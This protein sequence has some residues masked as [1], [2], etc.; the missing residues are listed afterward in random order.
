MTTPDARDSTV[1]APDP[2]LAKGQVASRTLQFVIFV[3][4]LSAVAVG[5][6]ADTGTVWWPKVVTAAGGAL[7]GTSLS[8][9]LASFQSE[10]VAARIAR[11]LDDVKADVGASRREVKS[12]LD[13]S[14]NAAFRSEGDLAPLKRRWHIYHLARTRGQWGWQAHVLDFQRCEEP[15]VLR[16][17]MES[18]S[19][20]GEPIHYHVDAGIRHGRLVIFLNDPHSAQGAHA[21]LVF[22]QAG[23]L[24][25]PHFGLGLVNAADGTS[26]V[27]PVAAYLDAPEGVIASAGNVT[28]GAGDLSRQ[29]KER[30]LESVNDLKLPDEV[31]TDLFEAK[32]R[33][34]QSEEDRDAALRR[35]ETAEDR[36]NKVRRSL[37]TAEV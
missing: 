20:E 31:L 22:P 34:K 7:V 16:T 1:D 26:A 17:E 33:L 18:L 21:V 29:W 8:L 15:G 30:F 24:G 37:E 2:S 32:A 10:D 14:L 28:S 13:R 4:G 19:S 23:L 27:V 9:M 11:L 3:V 5:V 25:P 12:I 36:L 35:A 6:W